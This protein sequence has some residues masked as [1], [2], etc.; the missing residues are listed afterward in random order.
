MVWVSGIRCDPRF[1]SKLSSSRRVNSRVVATVHEAVNLRSKA[2]RSG[3]VKSREER[4]LFWR[5]C[6]YAQRRGSME[7]GA[8]VMD[9]C[10]VTDAKRG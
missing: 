1:A 9:G 3:P 2:A 6:D 7:N 10:F 8:A 5:A 4:G